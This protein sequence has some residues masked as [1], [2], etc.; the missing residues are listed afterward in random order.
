MVSPISM[1]ALELGNK[2]VVIREDF[3]VPIQAGKVTNDTRI[4]SALP[5]IKKAIAANAR[6]ILLSHLGRPTEGEY[7]KVYSL[8]PVAERL[9]QLLGQPVAFKQDWLNG[10]ECM[11]GQVVMCEN[12]RFNEGEKDNYEVLAK[13][14]AALCDVFIMDAFASSHRAQ[15][16]TH[17]I[18][19]FTPVACAG[20]LLITELDALKAA[21][22]AP[23]HPVLAIV[24]GSKVSTKLTLLDALQKIVDN[25]IVGG[26][27]ANTFLAA[28][29]Y[30]IGKSLS[31]VDLIQ[32]ATTFSESQIPLPFDVMV[33]KSFSADQAAV[34]KNIDAV[35]DDDM[36]LDIGPRTIDGYLEIIANAK[37]IIWNGP[38]GVFEFPAFEHGTKA[39]AN[40]IADSDAFSIAG[41][42]DTIAAIDKYGIKEKISYISTGGGAFLE[43]LEGKTLPAIEVL[44]Q[45]AQEL[46]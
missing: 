27:I 46:V 8:A 12:V 35:A 41:G 19:C 9:S 1:D 15:A 3:N 26:G 31:E 39:I 34:E 45:R 33:A 30:P 44:Q 38:V 23:L 4:R 25:L 14:M 28:R 37:T 21:M 17:G 20:P 18:A 11:P 13:Q 5:T 40:A 24:G 43:Y 36:I 7:D 10:V 42:G 22:Q 6:V 29:G 32:Q 2:R 16:S